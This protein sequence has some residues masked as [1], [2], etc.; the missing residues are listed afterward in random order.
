MSRKR[1]LVIDDE[2]DIR[3]LLEITLGRMQIN[4]DS[5]DSVQRAKDHLEDIEKEI[6]SSALETA[7]WNR[8]QAAKNL[9]ISFRSLRYRLRK[10]GLDED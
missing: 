7:K 8:T 6:L 9:G 2:P 4:T 3:E 5:V 1:A 10:L